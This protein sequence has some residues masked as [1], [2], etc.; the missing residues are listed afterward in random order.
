MRCCCRLC[1]FGLHSY[2]QQASTA[3]Q[4]GSCPVWQP[5][6]SYVGVDVWVLSPCTL[7]VYPLCEV[8]VG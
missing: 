5:S 4:E 7:T 6:H 1:W 8:L 2:V 3:V